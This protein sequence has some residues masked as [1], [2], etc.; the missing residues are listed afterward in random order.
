MRWSRCVKSVVWRWSM[1]HLNSQDRPVSP[2]HVAQAVA[3]ESHALMYIHI[4]KTGL[5]V[6]R[7]QCHYMGSDRSRPW[8]RMAWLSS[9]GRRLS[10]NNEA[11][12]QPMSHCCEAGTGLRAGTH[13]THYR[14][15]TTRHNL[16]SEMCSISSHNTGTRPFSRLYHENKYSGYSRCI[17]LPM[18][19][20]MLGSDTNLEMM[21]RN[22][23][24]HRE[25][26]TNTK[27][28]KPKS[29]TDQR[30]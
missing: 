15:N 6:L 20:Q 14:F 8:W 5:E 19:D 2:S 24:F 16:T 25:T 18:F 28:D 3:K 10:A 27:L 4:A 9:Q 21:E 11:E 26:V 13:R 7:T 22:F 17:F 30:L 29:P 23:S 1:C 12:S